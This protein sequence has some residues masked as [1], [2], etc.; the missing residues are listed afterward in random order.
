MNLLTLDPLSI[1]T[2]LLHHEKANEFLR[3]RNGKQ[4]NH[5]AWACDRI[6]WDKRNTPDKRLAASMLGGFARYYSI[7]VAGSPPPYPR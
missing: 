7:I 6:A 1:R 4:L 2:A 3:R 5:I